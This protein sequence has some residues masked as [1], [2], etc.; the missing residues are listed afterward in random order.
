MAMGVCSQP[1][2][3][4]RSTRPHEEHFPMWVMKVSHVLR[5]TGHCGFGFDCL[6]MENMSMQREPGFWSRRHACGRLA[7]QLPGAAAG[8][9]M[10]RPA[11]S[12]VSF[13]GVR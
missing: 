11:G 7:F 3:H 4:R 10:E 12:P 5:M 6:L 2:E 1:V 9:L 8:L 13:G